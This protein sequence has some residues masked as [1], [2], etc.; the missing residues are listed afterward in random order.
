[1][2]MLMLMLMLTP[3][4]SHFIAIQL[5]DMNIADGHIFQPDS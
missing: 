1:M 5:S 3:P 4:T 2:L